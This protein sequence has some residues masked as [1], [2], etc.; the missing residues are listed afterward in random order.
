[1]FC[2]FVMA[3][4]GDVSVYSF[5]AWADGNLVHDDWDDDTF[6]MI[7]GKTLEVQIRYENPYNT[8]IIISTKAILYDIKGD[9]LERNKDIT[10]NSGERGKAIVFEYYIPVDTRLGNNDL[11]IVFQYTYNGT[12]YK[13]TEIFEV[14]FKQETIETEDVLTNLT[15]TIANGQSRTNEIY[16]VLVTI[17][18]NISKNQQQNID[19]MTVFTNNCSTMLSDYKIKYESEQTSKSDFSNRLNTCIAEKS[20]MYSQSQLD[21]EKRKAKSEQKQQSEGNMLWIGIIIAIVWWYN[22][23]KKQVKG[24]GESSTA[25]FRKPFLGI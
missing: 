6:N 19:V 15:K 3:T 17:G 8:S 23:Q 24:Q 13:H 18:Q 5:K 7:V 22:R 25:T 9:D 20:A 1:M 21:E 16:N 4:E 14:S 12:T 10:I 2:S 11:E